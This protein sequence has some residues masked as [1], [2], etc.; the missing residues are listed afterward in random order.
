MPLAPVT[1]T[2]ALAGLPLAA[3]LWFAVGDVMLTATG[4]MTV[5]LIAGLTA[6]AP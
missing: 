6:T 3:M 5:T 1:V 4:A 2:L